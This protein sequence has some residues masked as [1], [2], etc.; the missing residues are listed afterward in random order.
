MPLGQIAGQVAPDVLELIRK[1]IFGSNVQNRS[2]DFNGLFGPLSNPLAQS[3]D[4]ESLSAL[5]E[6]INGGGGP[7]T[8]ASGQAS[9]AGLSGVNALGS[10]VAN[11]VMSAVNPLAPTAVNAIG[12]TPSTFSAFKDFIEAVFHPE[13]FNASIDNNAPESPNANDAGLSQAADSQAANVESDTGDGG[14][15]DGSGDGSSAGGTGSSAGNAGDADG[16]SGGADAGDG[17]GSGG[18]FTGGFVPGASPG[19]DNKTINVEGG[20]FVVPSDIVEM[21]GKNFFEDLMLTRSPL[22]VAA[23]K[24]AAKM[25]KGAK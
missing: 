24:E 17:G 6:A 14:G 22:Q 3:S 13:V 1:T 18:F 21:L 9:P 25:S 23:E 10:V 12:H 4:S 8:N 11:A 7:G 16:G 19:F 20:E 2:A 5:T 15:T